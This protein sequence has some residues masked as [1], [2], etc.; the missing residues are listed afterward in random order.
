MTLYDIKPGFQSLLRP[1]VKWLAAKG[2]TANQVTLAAAAGSIAVGILLFIFSRQPAVFLILP[3]WMFIRM[4][5]SAVDGMLAREFK[6]KSH[7][8]AYLNELC[9]VLSDA[10]LFI[11]FALIAP[12]SAGTVVLVIF[13]AM[14]SE[15]A[16]VIGP[17][18]GASRRYD[19][20]LG[21][22]DRA[23]IFGALGLWLGMGGVMP[24]WL[25][26]LM[27]I[28]ALLLSITI[29]NRTKQALAEVR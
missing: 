29:F 14:L 3:V 19:G 6:Q 17:V 22:S 25:F 4:A 18:I 24:Q 8:G 7:L 26:W 28:L 21:K 15:F 5:L 2:I 20:P 23:L 16:G 1:M 11:P 9:D 12:F 13:L 10:A 27:P